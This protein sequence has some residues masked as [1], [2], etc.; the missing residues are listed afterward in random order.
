MPRARVRTDSGVSAVD[1]DD[2][3]VTIDGKTHVVEETEEIDLLP[4]CRP[5]GVYCLGR[6]YPGYVEE[7]ADTI[8]QNLDHDPEIPDETHL[9]LKSPASV[10][11]PGDPIPYPTFSESVGYAGE[12]AAV[13]DRSCKH[14][15]PEDVPSIVRGYTILNDVDAK[16]QPNLIK[17]KVFDGSAPLGPAIADVDPLSLE[18]RTEING[19]VRQDASTADMHRSPA[20][21]IADISER[22]TL[23]PGD[24]ISM[25]S[26]ANPGTVEPGD[27]IEVWYE[28][29]GTLRNTV[30]PADGR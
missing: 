3:V 19:T 23:Q 8:R 21:A 26:P 15:A 18:M 16:D 14:V 11:G 22:V 5:G 27:T 24:V 10:V 17:M 25:G 4:P 1:Y 30:A 7:N 29:I 20:E 2:G 12:L 28:G 13:I 9:F 6:N